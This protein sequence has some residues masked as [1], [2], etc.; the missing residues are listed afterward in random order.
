MQRA[1]VRWGARNRWSPTYTQTCSNHEDSFARIFEEKYFQ[2]LG[3]CHPIIPASC[4]LQKMGPEGGENLFSKISFLGE[5]S[6]TKVGICHLWGWRL[7]RNPKVFPSPFS[8]STRQPT[9]S[10][11]GKRCRNCLANW[12]SAQYIRCKQLCP[13]FLP[14]TLHRPMP[15]E[16]RRGERE[17][18]TLVVSSFLSPL[19]TDRSWRGE[20]DQYV[21]GGEGGGQERMR[22]A[23]MMTV[24]LRCCC[25]CFFFFSPRP[26]FVPFWKRREEN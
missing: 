21:R 14:L 24:F 15:R 7:Q 3:S 11:S 2:L 25:W 8:F 22:P 20:R 19:G 4:P 12:T 18:E 26:V 9:D 16:P 23:M 1:R 5:S 10:F 17:R 6:P 13:T